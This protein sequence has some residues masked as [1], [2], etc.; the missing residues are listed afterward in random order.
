[1]AVTTAEWDFVQDDN[2]NS[3]TLLQIWTQSSHRTRKAPSSIRPTYSQTQTST[4]SAMNVYGDRGVLSGLRVPQ[5]SQIRGVSS[6]C[7]DD[8][9]HQE[10][11]V[12]P[13]ATVELSLCSAAIV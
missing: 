7:S 4:L 12:E 8:Q 10:L 6:D 3:V 13:P 2:K 11:M 9:V 5:T 1:M